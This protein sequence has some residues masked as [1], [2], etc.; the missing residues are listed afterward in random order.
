MNNIEALA[1]MIQLDHKRNI[2]FGSSLRTGNDIDT[3]AS[4]GSKELTGNTGRAFHSFTHNGHCGQIAF[5]KNFVDLTH[6]NFVAELLFEYL[7]SEFGLGVAHA[8]RSSVLRRS[9]RNQ[10]NRNTGFGQS[11]KNP[12]IHTDDSDHAQALYGYKAGIGY[13]RNPFNGFAFA[14]YFV[15][16]NVSTLSLGV[17]GI[18]DADGYIFVINRKNGRRINHL[19]SK[20]TEFHGFHITQVINHISIVDHFRIGRHKTVHI[21]PDLQ[22][23]SIEFRGQNR[24]CVIG[25]TPANVGDFTALGITRNKAAHNRKRR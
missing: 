13:G 19:G 5:C 1:Q 22:D 8:N 16:R 6:F 2:G 20:I 12:V 7:H 25:A 18:L 10:E 4:Q 15:A 9:L 3:I 23:G 14:R 21:G 17:E 11:F 24:S